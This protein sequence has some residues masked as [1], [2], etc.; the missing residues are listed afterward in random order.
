MD[1]DTHE[2][3][4]KPFIEI[5]DT[6][7]EHKLRSIKLDIEPPDVDK[8]VEDKKLPVQENLD[9]IDQKSDSIKTIE[10][11]WNDNQEISLGELEDDLSHKEESKNENI[12][13]LTTVPKQSS[14]EVLDQ[15]EPEKAHDKPMVENKVDLFKDMNMI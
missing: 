14:V 8:K 5:K 13:S 6:V 4:E 9:K 7:D 3:Q 1:Q 10:E 11:G 15:S 12:E 2:G